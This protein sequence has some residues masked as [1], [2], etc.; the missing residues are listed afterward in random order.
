[1]N[2]VTDVT[3]ALVS[4]HISGRDTI[5]YGQDQP[6][7][8]RTHITYFNRTFLPIYALNR[9]GIRAYIPPTTK[10]THNLIKEHPSDFIIRQTYEIDKISFHAMQEAL[11]HQLSNEDEDEILK[12]FRLEFLEQIGNKDFVKSVIHIDYIIDRTQIVSKGMLY[13]APLDLVIYPKDLPVKPIHPYSPEALR[14]DGFNCFR[15]KNLKELD[16]QTGL[17]VSIEVIDNENHT[18]SKFFRFGEEIHQVKVN[19]AHHK[20]SGVRL[21][22][23]DQDR[24]HLNV[25]KTLSLEEAKSA[26]GLYSTHEE[27]VDLGDLKL[28]RQREV[29][30][31][32]HRTAQ[33][34]L[35]LKT[36]S[37][38]Y[39]AKLKEK[40]HQHKLD[41]INIERE[42]KLAEQQ[43]EQQ[44]YVLDREKQYRTDEYERKSQERKDSSEIIKMI[45]IILTAAIGIGAIL[46][47]SK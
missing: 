45:P 31:L 41:L 46:A 35:E 10:H 25:Q 15:E 39:E 7:G 8:V 22:I 11:S 23:F 19:K 21:S 9:N 28:T 37:Q 26:I 42:N 29:D 40:E 14:R 20:P 4:T 36:R 2:I 5:F 16:I 27:A 44:R 3:N 6:E 43:R 13:I 18:Q 17:V 32:K 1:M 47:K 30:E 33:L 12:K 34:A 38:D 24:P